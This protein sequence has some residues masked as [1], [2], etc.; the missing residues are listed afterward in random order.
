MYRN[1][2]N[3]KLMK[4]D[5][6]VVLTNTLVEN[7]Y[8]SVI[9]ILSKDPVMLIGKPGM[10]KSLALSVIDSNMKGIDSEMALCAFIK[11]AGRFSFPSG[12][13]AAAFV[14]A[15]LLGIFYPVVATLALAFALLVGL[16][17][18]LL[19]VHYP[20][21]IAAGALLGTSCAMIGSL[22]V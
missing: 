9:C 22:F 2:V 19:G 7:I 12:H 1:L 11:P 14:M 21:D 5:G 10:S 18:V 3:T 20:S 13:T 8:V 16:S 4:I 6:D 17:R 15:T